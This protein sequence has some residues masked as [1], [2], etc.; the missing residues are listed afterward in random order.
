MTVEDHP[1]A[2]AIKWQEPHSHSTAP[3]TFITRK[4]DEK[5]T[6]KASTGG[7]C[8]MFFCY[9]TSLSWHWLSGASG[10]LATMTVCR[11]YQ[12]SLLDARIS[13]SSKLREKYFWSISGKVLRIQ[14]LHRHVSTCFSCY[15]LWFLRSAFT[16]MGIARSME[17]VAKRVTLAQISSCGAA[18]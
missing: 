2:T 12:Y 16:F 3:S 15:V 17:A 13:N 4:P 18:A 7:A 5:W 6:L 10:T 9:C 1:D 8:S 14:E 11:I